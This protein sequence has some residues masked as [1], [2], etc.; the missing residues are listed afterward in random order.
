ME[1]ELNPE[2]DLDIDLPNLSAEFREF[3]L[4][5]YR[6]SQYRAQIEAKRD[7][8]KAKLK[9]LRAT[10]YKKIKSNPNEKHTQSSLEAEVDSDPLVMSAMMTLIRAEHDANT[11]A[12][13]VE[14][15]RAKKD[16]LIQL[17]SDRRKEI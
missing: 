2:K 3:P 9:E 11:W 8:A 12:G 17:G 16:C 6:Y 1:I 14:S 13:A 15:M 10:I 4:K 7:T 5:M